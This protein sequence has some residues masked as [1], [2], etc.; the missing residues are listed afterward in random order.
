MIV[1]G[2][3]YQMTAQEVLSDILNTVQYNKIEQCLI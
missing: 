3:G 1:F 2:G